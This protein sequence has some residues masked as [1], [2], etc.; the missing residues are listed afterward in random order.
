MFANV[1]KI[2][3]SHLEISKLPYTLLDIVDRNHEA[4]ERGVWGFEPR[5][6]GFLGSRGEIG[7]LPSTASVIVEGT[8][9][10]LSTAMTQSTA[11]LAFLGACGDD[12]FWAKRTCHSFV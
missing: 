10:L 1:L 2:H 3:Q 4:Q 5:E 8:P 11:S 9:R 7:V 6:E 12:A